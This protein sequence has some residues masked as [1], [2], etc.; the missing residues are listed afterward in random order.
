MSDDKRIKYGVKMSEVYRMRMTAEQKRLISQASLAGTA[1]EFWRDFDV[2]TA[3]QLLKLQAGELTPVEFG[4][5]LT[6]FIQ[7]FSATVEHPKDETP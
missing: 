3:E 5:N 2:Y 6:N 1:S 4:S 7:V